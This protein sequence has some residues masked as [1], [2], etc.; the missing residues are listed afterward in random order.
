[1]KSFVCYSDFMNSKGRQQQGELRSHKAVCKLLTE[2]RR[3]K[4]R[5]R[6]KDPSSSYTCDMLHRTQGVKMNIVITKVMTIDEKLIMKVKK[7]EEK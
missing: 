4:R 3:R 2:R 5:E 7:K 1:M 6:E